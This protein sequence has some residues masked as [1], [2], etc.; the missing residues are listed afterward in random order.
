LVADYVQDG[1]W[2]ILDV[3]FQRGASL[4]PGWAVC[5]V[6]NGP[7]IPFKGPNDLGF[8]ELIQSFKVKMLRTGM[9]V[10]TDP[11]VF[12]TD[13]L[14]TSDQDPSRIRSLAL[15][16]QALKQNLNPRSKPSFVLVLLC[17]KDKCIY[18]S[19]KRLGDVRQSELALASAR[20]YTSAQVVL[21]LNTVCMLLTDRGALVA[22]SKKR[23]QYYSNVALKVSDVLY[24][25]LPCSPPR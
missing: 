25:R 20:S 2:N 3:K 13:V 15:I 21:G 14:P 23:D 7:R 17:M 9:V 8:I 18:S 24:S 12:S 11:M 6:L 1:G 19:I 5:V 16:K 22:D 4:T 10:P